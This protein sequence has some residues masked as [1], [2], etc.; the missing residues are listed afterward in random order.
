[1]KALIVALGISIFLFGC[2]TEYYK[3]SV[4]VSGNGNYQAVPEKAEYEEGETVTITAYA[5]SGWRFRRWEGSTLSSKTNP[6]K[7]VMDGKKD[8][9]VV[10]GIPVEP[11]LTGQWECY[12]YLITFNIEQP[13]PFEKNLKGNLN[14]KLNDGS[15]VVYNV[16]GSN[17]SPQ[18]V[19]TCT[20]TG[21]YNITYNGTLVNDNRI[22]G[23]LTEAG[24]QY[25]CNL[26][27]VT[28]SPLNGERIPFSV[29]KISD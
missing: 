20:R 6:L 16:T 27:R 5:D 13:D 17:N 8:I 29:H 12:F 14:I 26:N 1:M 23:Y 7:I 22:T 18:V 10:F 15:T 28:D 3:L 2:E 25:S 19:M 11:D 21:Y 24:V 4:S 9:R